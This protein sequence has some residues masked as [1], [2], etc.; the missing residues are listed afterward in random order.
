AGRLD[1]AA[2]AAPSVQQHGRRSV[3]LALDATLFTGPQLAPHWGDVDL[4]GGWAMPMAPI[5]VDI[6]QIEAHRARST[7]AAKDAAQAF[8]KALRDQGIT[9]DGDITRAQAPEE[10]EQLGA[11]KSAE[12]GRIVDYTLRHSENVLSETLGRMTAGGTDQAASI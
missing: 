10:A 6:G 1:L 2:D 12:L 8:A 5:A 7:D 9:V 11:V 4:S 3:H